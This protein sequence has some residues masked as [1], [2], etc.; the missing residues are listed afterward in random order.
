MAWVLGGIWRSTVWFLRGL[1]ALALW[2]WWS[3]VY[4][5]KKLWRPIGWVLTFGIARFILEL[6]IG[7]TIRVCLES[8][9]EVRA[10]RKEV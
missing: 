3:T 7:V 10:Q 4:L 1:W 9:E 8:L 2:A 5:L 6:A